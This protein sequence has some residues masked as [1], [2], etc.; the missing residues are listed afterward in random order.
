M[1]NFS[2]VYGKKNRRPFAKII[3]PKN[4]SS[5]YFSK[6]Q[7]T[8]PKKIWEKQRK[9]LLFYLTQEKLISINN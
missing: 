8:S 1:G 2:K 4:K 5:K 3:S 9:R 6:A 7:K